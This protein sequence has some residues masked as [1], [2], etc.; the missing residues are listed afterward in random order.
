MTTLHIGIDMHGTLITDKDEKIPSHLV[1]PLIDALQNARKDGKAK[2][3]LCTGN[4]LEFVRRKIEP[5]VLEQLDGHILEMGCVVS[6]DGKTEDLLLPDELAGKMRELGQKLKAA[7]FPEVYK[8]G[9]RLAIV[10]LFTKFGIRPEELLPKVQQAINDL[11]FAD[12]ARPACSSVAVDIAPFGYSKLT[13]MRHV[14]SG[15]PVMGIA[16]SM[17]DLELIIG[18]DKAVVPGN[19]RPALLDEIIKP[20][21]SNIQLSEKHVTE[22]VIET[23]NSVADSDKEKA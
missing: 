7:G 9:R 8:F 6:H 4:D 13:G 18:A 17:N 19:A 11:G 21:N 1:E 2:V 16:D 23:L 5:E 10:T 14:A 15:G 3:Y 20:N 22:A 12:V